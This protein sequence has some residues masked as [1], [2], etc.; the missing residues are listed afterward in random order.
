MG[1]N[2]NNR[3]GPNVGCIHHRFE[4]QAELTPDAVAVTYANKRLTYGELNRKA[5]QLAA[6]LQSLGVG[7]EVLVGIC[8]ERSLEMVVGI[9]AVL[10]AGGAYLP[11]DPTY[12]RDRLRFMLEN[13]RAGVLVTENR[14]A[15]KLLENSGSAAPNS[16]PRYSLP[17]SHVVCLDADSATIAEQADENLSIGLRHEN[18]AYVIY[19]SGSTGTPKGV[20]VTHHNVTRLLQATEAWFR[21]DDTDV[22]TMFHSYAFDF[23][24]WEIWGALCYGGRLVVVPYTVSRS[25]EQF[26]RLLRDERVTV[27]NQTPS[28]FRQLVLAMIGLVAPEQMVLRH[29]I[30][31]GEAL[32]LGCLKPWIDRYGDARPQLTNMYGITE[33]TVHVTYRPISRADVRADPGSLIGRP[34]TDLQVHVL[35]PQLQGVAAGAAGELYV[36][37]AGTA[38]GYLNRPELTA[39]RFVPDPI[40]LLPGARIYKSGDL[41]RYLADGDLEYLGR[42]DHQVKIRG[43]RIE[44]EEIEAVLR[45]HPAVREAVVL[46]RD[47]AGEKS[48]GIQSEKMLVAYSVPDREKVLIGPELRRFLRQK[49]PE[50]MVP[51]AFVSLDALPLTSNGKIDRHSLPAPGRGRPDLSAP[52]MPPRTPAEETLADIWAEVLGLAEVGRDDDF[53]ELGGHSLRAVQI[54]SRVRDAFR[55]EVPLDA[56]FAAPTVAGLARF[57]SEAQLGGRQPSV[58]PLPTSPRT[59]PVPVSFSQERA[60]FIQQLNP[61]NVAYNSQ[62]TLRF[63]G[64][65]DIGA[66]E[67]SLTEIVRRHEIFRTTFP[68]VQGRPVQVIHPAWPVRL[69]VVSF[70]ALPDSERE[71]EAQRWI[72]EK[73]REPFDL[74]RLPLVRWSLVRIAAREQILVHVEHHLVHDGW[75]FTVF[76]RELTALYRAFSSGNASPLRELPVQFADF[77]LWQRAWMQGAV[78]EFELDYWKTRLA[79]CPALALPTDHPRPPVQSLRGTAPRAEIPLRLYESLRALS[80][81]EGVTLFVTMF[82]AFLVLLH[83]YSGQR[84]ICVGSGIANRRWRETEGLIGMMINNVAIRGDLSGDPRFRELLRRIRGVTL[85]AFAHQDLPFDHVVK[86]LAPERDLSRNPLFQVMFSFHDSPMPELNFPGLKCELAEALSSGSA[87]FDLNIIAIPRLEQRL[88]HGGDA[89]AASFTLI[90]EYATDLFDAATIARM[91]DHY[92]ILLEGIVADPERRISEMPM[93]A[94]VERRRILVEWN[95]TNRSYPRDSSVH[96]LFERQAE[97]SPDRI[98]VIYGPKQLTYRELNARTDHLACRL[99]RLGVGPEVLVGI[100]MKRSL[101]MVVGLL[102]ILKAGGAYLPLDP[103]YPKQRL[104]LML[105]Q[106]DAQVL[107]TQQKLTAEFDSL[108]SIL[109]SGM[110]V[111][112]LDSESEALDEESDAAPVEGASADNLAYVMFT[113]GSTGAPKGV[114][115]THR[116]V[117]RLVKGQS[118]A[119]LTEKEVFLQFAPLSFDA[120][121]FEIWAPLLNGGTLVVAPAG[122]LSGEELARVIDRSKVSTLWLTSALFQ[123]M[124]EEHLAGLRGI[125]Q[126]LAGGDVLPVPHVKRALETLP[127][128]RLINGYGPTENTTFSCCYPMSSSRQLGHSVPIGRPIANTQAYVLDEHLNPVPA[129]VPGELYVGGD[130]LARGYFKDPA[131]TAEKFIPNPFEVGLRFYRTGDRA[132]CRADG[133]VEFLGRIDN[134]VKIRGFRIEPGEIESVLRQHPGVREAVVSARDETTEEAPSSDSP[135]AEIQNPKSNRRLVAYVVPEGDLASHS[136][137]RSFLGSRLPDH[138]IPSAFVFMAALP[139]SPNGKVNRR[140]LP[141]PDQ[142][143]PDLKMPFVAA[144]TSVEKAIAKIWSEVLGL[145]KIGAHDNFFDLGGHSLLATQVVSRVCEVFQIDLPLRSLFEN[146]TVAGFAAQVARVRQAP[147]EDTAGVLAELEALSDEEAHELLARKTSKTT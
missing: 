21:F 92:R 123:A 69:E 105:E 70:E 15:E 1:R 119:D 72:S 50:H 52:F 126:L 128:C 84:D 13:A 68:A 42:I 7:P 55:I 79:G 62:S 127:E 54:V 49:L 89:A 35:D 47:N 121:T 8:H 135:K 39:E 134:Q 33:T 9:L 146:P 77:A 48:D 65:L 112:D 3:D 57:A 87:K 113:S 91:I 34:I 75:S 122:A 103:G 38:R 6:H 73:F 136:E 29:V 83:R 27:L 98:A 23:S 32:D 109:D 66:L 90:W 131:L 102:G 37:G 132:R 40:S 61:E 5:N 14:L 118:Y 145:R 111:L 59:G 81:R 108:S 115:V 96:V 142:N 129:G 140:E 43:F 16:H 144:E 26:S 100:F 18:L 60:W 10:K 76:L 63:T 80:R 31:G 107:L 67:R 82:S 78:A 141:A 30:F 97:Q 117:T 44:L 147:P 101:E 45:E 4:I 124:V 133:N 58:P 17:A 53:F 28:A 110:K 22:W 88:G 36:G 71:G 130:G 104:A 143:R 12:P 51:A 125:K 86:A 116:N 46:A 56:F 106:A 74:T 19:T 85:E 24:V 20:L 95:D 2:D 94:D 120:S 64:T 25:P 138:M 137:L 139:L 114:A 11:L 41:V 93:L 99:R